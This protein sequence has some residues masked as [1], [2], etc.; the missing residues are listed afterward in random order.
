MSEVN[1]HVGQRIDR[2]GR[3]CGASDDFEAPEDLDLRRA[4]HRIAD[5]DIV[6]RF[7]SNRIVSPAPAGASLDKIN[8]AAD[9]FGKK[10]NP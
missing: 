8:S 2:P 5:S 9:S 7:E 6:Y 3:S 4:G 10:E 1:E